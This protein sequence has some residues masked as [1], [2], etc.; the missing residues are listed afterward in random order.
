MVSITVNKWDSAHEGS[1]KSCIH[2]ASEL[3]RS[4]EKI[5][6]YQLPTPLLK[7][8]LAPGKFNSLSLPDRHT[9]QYNW[10]GSYSIFQGRDREAQ[11]Q[12]I[13]GKLYS[14]DTLWSGYL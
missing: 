9:S 2:C 13:R 7:G 11:E 4:E 5:L 3:S 12:T 10:T 14:L 1:L 8:G 6:M